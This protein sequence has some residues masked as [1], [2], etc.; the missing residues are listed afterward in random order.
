MTLGSQ[1]RYI[2][3]ACP[4]DCPDTCSWIVT[5]KQGEAVALRG[6]PDHPYTRG[7]LCNKVVDYLTYARSRD[8]LLY[9]MR[10][11][12]PK[13]SGEFSRISWDEALDEIAERFRDVIA[14]DGAE[15]IWPI[16][17]SGSMGLIQGIYGAGR[18]LWNVL[19]T[20]RNDYNLCTIAGGF[21]TGYTLGDNKVGMDPE[22]FR[23]SKLIVL[24]GANV[25]STHPHLWRPILEA[26]KSGGLVVTIDP[27]RTRTAA[28]SDWHLAP[29][30][31]TD[32][33]LALG[34]MGVVLTQGKEDQQFIDE[35]TVGWE[36]FR[37]RILEFPPSRAAA[38]TGLPTQAI[39]DLGKRLA[40]TRPT[41]IRI[42]I[43]LQRHGGGGMAVRTISCIPGVTGD[44]RYPGGGVF[45][46]TRGFFG[47]NWEALW[48]DDLRP[49]Q[50][51]ALDMKRLGEILLQ[52]NTPRVNALF[53]Y[54]SNPAASVPNQK[55]V[56]CGLARRD[57]FSV[58][59]E[60]FLTDTARYADIILPATMQIEHRDLLIAYGHLYIAWN[61]PAVPPLGE[62]LPTTE[63]F[64]RLGRE[65]GLDELAL[66]DSDETMATQL[67]DSRH[68]SLEGIT[69][70]KLKIRGWMRLN[71][72]SPFVPFER[73][74]PT[75]SSKLEFVSERM[76]QAGLDPVA[77]Y[78]P[79]HEMSQRDTFLAR[80]YPLALITPANH[81]FLNSIFAN[82]PRQQRRA[83]V[84]TLLIHPDDAEPRQIAGGDEVRVVNARG[85]FFA[86]ADVSDC[87]RPGV[88]ASSKGRWPCDSKQGASVN[89]TVD[90]RDSDMGGGAVY[91]DN[92]VRVDKV[93]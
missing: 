80:E 61:E 46:D 12:G 47:L 17:G 81:Y 28:A 33:A 74:F 5:V 20:S 39:I 75:A 22:S 64:R 72:P 78:T 76:A 89:A 58:V 16:A 50:T 45:Y 14:R 60:H 9:P 54:A 19:G 44:W 62:C 90:D 56:L 84:P 1:T 26:R 93:E 52:T 83:G 15:A 42:G 66:Y 7:S 88:V 21:G 69:L 43:G 79:T 82:I 4:L 2:R 68:P 27:I 37:Q 24:W 91:H 63:I 70:E 65:L 18:R 31:G 3:G 67:L 86:V 34:L 10:R 40:E 59:I 71:Y 57:L 92:R 23:F 87:V 38:M 49:R 30:P 25:L 85:S 51:R 73:F 11:I 29:I 41:G 36:K 55:K 35:H 8:R 32:A 13:G 6:D 77:G 53:V 48:R